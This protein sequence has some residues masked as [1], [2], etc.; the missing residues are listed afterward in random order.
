MTIPIENSS[1]QLA[2]DLVQHRYNK[3]IELENKLRSSIQSKTPSDPNIWAQMRENYEAIILE[4][5]D[6][7]ES[8]EIEHALWHL[9]YKRIEDFR[10][11]MRNAAA[12]ASGNIPSQGGK[13]V[14]R[15]EQVNK[16]RSVFKFSF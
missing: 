12:A 15:R 2:R 3:T 9:H 7:S 6:F 4:D 8:H 11:R 13:S 14:L 5:H 10:A 1:G 16:I